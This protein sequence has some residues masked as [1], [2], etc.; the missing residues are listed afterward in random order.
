MGGG[1]TLIPLRKAAAKAAGDV[2]AETDPVIDRWA[3]A[4]PFSTILEVIG[5]EN[6]SFRKSAKGTEYVTFHKD[7]SGAIRAARIAAGASEQQAA[8]ALGVDLN[9]YVDFEENG[10]E[11]DITAANMKSLAK[12][13]KMPVEE[14][15][16]QLVAT[17]KPV[18]PAMSGEGNATS[19]DQSDPPG[20]GSS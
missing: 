10:G 11:L 8:D 17:P 19:G 1:G 18:A 15:A 14:L 2:F 5:G 12:A 9:D 16:A 7:V 6:L 3:K 20:S 13:F 4:E